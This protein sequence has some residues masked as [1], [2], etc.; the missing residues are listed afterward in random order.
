[1]TVTAPE[2]RLRYGDTVLDTG[3]GGSYEHRNPYSGELQAVI[4]L[5]GAAEIDGA[6]EAA[7]AAVESWRRWTPE[8]RRDVLNRFADLLAEHRQQFAELQALDGGTP[9]QFGLRLVDNTIT[10]TRYYA[11]WCDKLSGQLISTLDTRGYFSY[12]APEPYGVVGLIMT[13][14]GPV[15]AL[16]MKVMPALAAGN[17]VVVKPSEF[18]PFAPQL[19]ARLLRE[20]GVPEGVC[21][22][23]PGGPEAGEALVRNP[24]VE[25]VSFTGGPAAG[26]AIMHACAE[27]LK[28]L[29]LELGGKTASIVFPDA[30]DLDGVAAR[31]VRDSIG[32]LA[33]QGCVIPTRLLVHADI[34][35]EVVERV[36]AVAATYRVGN[37]LEPD[38]R[39]GPLINAAAVERV[40]GMLDRARRDGAGRFVLGGGRAGGDLAGKN[41]V[42][43]TIIADADPQHEIS[44]VEIFGPVL[45]VYRFETDDE[46]VALA[47]STPYGLG[48][49]IQS[50]DLTRV[51]RLAERLKAGGVYVN[52]ARQNLPHTPFGGIGISGFGREGGR[53]GIDEFLRYKTVSIIEPD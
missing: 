8:A 12:T 25:K 27:Q 45:L 26:R 42:E 39:V 38:V 4:P 34:Y 19:Y 9:L 43:P 24:K 7:A 36:T 17:C 23:L 51:H 28:P 40:C 37:P 47:N 53:A 30:A 15:I 3:S 32:V 31:A 10:W 11:G 44:Q 5:A 35:D 22:I 6:V 16:G 52:G 33:G 21:S 1:M 13:W 29:L 2:V 50:T 18:T 48:A 46:A 14:N 49:N 20:A 41:F